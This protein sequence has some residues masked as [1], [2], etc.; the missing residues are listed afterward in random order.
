MVRYILI[1]VME[2]EI[3][4]PEFFDTYENA[5][6]EMRS[7]ISEVLGVSFDEIAEAYVAGGQ[8]DDDTF[9]IEGQAWTEKHGQNFD[10]KIFC[11]S[12]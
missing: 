12:F 2:R 8:Y 9:I 11:V 1:E 5:H 4:V 10:W 7:R 3:S 6:R